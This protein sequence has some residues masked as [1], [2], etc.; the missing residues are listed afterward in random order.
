MDRTA[1]TSAPVS[2]R[3]DVCMEERLS[4]RESGRYI[5]E[6]CLDGNPPIGRRSTVKV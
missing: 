3:C 1:R 2:D 5:C 4:V 6:I